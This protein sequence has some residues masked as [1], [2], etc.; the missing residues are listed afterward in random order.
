MDS[1]TTN[2]VVTKSQNQIPVWG[3]PFSPQSYEAALTADTDKAF[4]IPAGMNVA[5]F[6]YSAGATVSVLQGT[7]GQTNSLPTGSVTQTTARI[8]PPVCQVNWKDD[9]GNQLYLHLIS[10]NSNDL[11][12]IGFYYDGTLV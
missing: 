12:N 1:L 3:L 4:A 7:V 2:L 9:S 6:G 8:N 11:V 10:P 5:I